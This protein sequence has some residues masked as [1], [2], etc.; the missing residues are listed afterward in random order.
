M[1]KEKERKKKYEISIRSKI[2]NGKPYIEA[3]ISLNFGIDCKTRLAKGGKSDEEAVLNL[4]SALFDYI[5]TS[6]ERGLVTCK[7]DNIVKDRIVSSLNELCL[8]TTK[9]APK[10]L[11][12][13]NLI[14]SI[15][16]HILD[17]IYFPNNVVPINNIATITAPKTL[18]SL[19]SKKENVTAPIVEENT[20]KQ[21]IAKTFF[22]EWV[23]YKFSLCKKTPD[24]PKPLCRK[25]ID[26]YYRKIRDNIMPYMIRHK[27]LYLQ[28][29]TDDFITGLLKSVNGQDGKRI[30][31]IVLNQL[32]KYA[33]KKKIVKDNPMQYIDKP[34]QIKKSE[35]QKAEDYIKPEEQ[36]IWLDAFEKENTDMSI[37]FETMLLAGL[38]PE[39]ACGIKWTSLQE[40]EDFLIINNAHKD[41]IVYDEN[42][43]PIGHERKDDTLKTSK[44]YRRVPL[45]P[46]LKKVLQKHKIK[47]Q[48][49]FRTSRALRDKKRKWTENEYMFL[50]RT[51]KPYV[52]DT[53]S[54]AMPKFRKKYN[55]TKNITP[56]GLRYSYASYWAQMGLDKISLMRA[57]GHESFETTERTLHKSI[58]RTY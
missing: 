46:R 16:A 30:T 4:L 9:I 58:T 53:L 29:L 43:N 21:Y 24:N 42:M 35:N 41:F 17:K 38:R 15:N 50:S 18:L 48:E 36:D 8:T 52:S 26:G 54:S 20:T 34:K 57:M 2:V 40:D 19:I 5:K 25:T 27:K 12:I 14:E 37:L 44:S 56:Y 45:D 33:I 39:E 47:Q 3:R 55:L 1:E 23:E 11:E 10:V 13:I 32:F 28:D 51:Y 7:I 31:Y 6:F 49:L 22:I